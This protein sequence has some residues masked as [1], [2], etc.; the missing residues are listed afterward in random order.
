MGAYVKLQKPYLVPLIGIPAHPT[1]IS[2]A[3]LSYMLYARYFSYNC[4]VT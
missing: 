4:N 3:F 1:L 2:R